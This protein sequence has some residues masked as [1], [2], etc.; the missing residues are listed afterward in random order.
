[1]SISP[2]LTRCLV[3]WFVIFCLLK[4]KGFVNILVFVMWSK[5]MNKKYPTNF[6]CCS[7]HPI[8]SYLLTTCICM[9]IYRCCCCNFVSFCVFTQ[10]EI[11]ELWLSCWIIIHTHFVEESRDV[12]L[13]NVMVNYW[14]SWLEFYT[15]FHIK[16]W[17]AFW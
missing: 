10:N 16:V 2:H 11:K 15:E 3:L 5:G 17:G 13:S 6:A 14:G 4:Q 8:V 7:A 12:F 1:M 9:Y